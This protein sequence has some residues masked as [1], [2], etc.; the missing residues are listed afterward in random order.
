MG[1]GDVPQKEMK[2]TRMYPEMGR[3]YRIPSGDADLGC[4]GGQRR[5]CCSGPGERMQPE[6]GLSWGCQ[7]RK[8][9]F[10]RPEGPRLWDKRGQIAV[11][12]GNRLE[13]HWLLWEVVG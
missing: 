8:R 11:K 13:I 4:F 5:V 1:S 12:R 6:L 10:Q 2:R 3:T 9:P 7:K